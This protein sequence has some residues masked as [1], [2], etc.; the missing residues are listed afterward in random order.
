MNTEQLLLISFLL[1]VGYTWAGYPGLL[2]IMASAFARPSMRRRSQPTVSIIIAAHNEE[3]CIGAKVSNCL[4]LEYPRECLEVIVASDGST[5]KTDQIVRE[6]AR[7][8]PRIRLLASEG[9]VGKSG[10]QNLAAEQARGDLLFLTD[11]NTRTPPEVLRI[12]ASNFGDPQVGLVSATI[13]F[14]TGADAVSKGQSLYWRY[15]YFLRQAES[16]IGILAT[17]S[18][19][20][21]VIRRDLYSPI[22]PRYGDDCILPL[23]V[24]LKGYLVLHDP[25]A[26]VF[27]SAPHSV[28]GELRSRIRMTARNWTGTLSR[29]SLLNPFRFPLT[30]LGLISHKLLRWLTP[31]LLLAI[32]ILNTG[33]LV[34]HQA[35]ALWVCQFVFYSCAF[36]GWQR[37]CRQRPAG[38]FGHPFSFCLANVGFLLGIAKAVRNQ[39]IVTY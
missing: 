30:A 33:L 32:F 27:D 29:P 25:Q 4:S 18:G 13:H 39:T 19:A 16:D 9:R 36:V 37:V 20:A 21:F 5:D 31:F 12:L 10:A 17:G 26:V 7:S 22:P 23:D 34:R 24:R 38:V 6:L 2:W 8:D 3:A 1:L 35:F 28:A 15:E 11:A 14:I